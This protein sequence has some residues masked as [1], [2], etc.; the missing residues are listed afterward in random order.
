MPS[1]FG[2]AIPCFNEAQNLEALL[3]IL[4][5]TK[6]QGR[7]AERFV[8]VSDDSRDGTN[9][10]VKRFAEK[11]STPLTLITNDECFGKATAINR[12]IR[13]MRDIDII[14][15]ISGDV[16]PDAG[17]IPLLVQQFE[18]PTV[19]V[20]AGRPVPIGPEGNLAFEITRLMWSLHHVIATRF[21][22]STEI[23]VFRNVVQEVDPTSLVDEAQLEV[24]IR[25]SGLSVVYR[26]DACILSPTPLRLSDYTNQRTRVTLGYL[27]LRRSEDHCMETQNLGER[28]RALTVV[29]REQRFSLP[30]VL[31]AIGLE[32]LIRGG[33]W[34]QFLARSRGRGI[35]ERSKS[36]KRS[37]VPAMV[38]G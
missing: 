11:T 21:P 29:L 6:V 7:A 31:L 20:A 15:L 5:E 33:A 13:E 12:C 30:V 19:G 35:W 10:I 28:M 25:R 3:R 16:L 4:D 27:R 32:I 14:V 23:T 37:P 24:A 22:K 26:P 9:E 38:N 17:C 2:F 18:D 36:T 8:I 1:T 34:I